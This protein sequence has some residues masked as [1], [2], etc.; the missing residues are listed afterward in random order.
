MLGLHYGSFKVHN[1][2]SIR[3]HVCRLVDRSV[4]W[5]VDWSVGRLVGYANVWNAQNGWLWRLPS[6]RLSHHLSCLTTFI[7]SF[8]HSFIYSF[9][10]SFIYNST[11]V[12]VVVVVVVVDHNFKNGL[13]FERL[14]RFASYLEG[15][16]TRVSRFASYA[17]VMIGPPQPAQPAY[18]PKSEKC[19]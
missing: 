5:L 9:I 12:G 2:T 15:S 11:R 16:C 6:F 18:Q 10:H 7:C 19:A 13:T 3:G 8:I 4:S 14:N 1:R 17:Y